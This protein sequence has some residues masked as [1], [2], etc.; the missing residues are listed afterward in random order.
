MKNRAAIYIR[1]SKEE[2]QQK[3][4]SLQMQRE[5]LERYAEEKGF[6]LAGIYCDDGQSGVDFE[7]PAFQAL[8]RDIEAGKID[9]LLTKDLSR[10]GRNSAR[11]TD[12]LD[13]YFPSKGVRYI[14]V[15]E[16]V[17]TQAESSANLIAPIANAV[18]ELYAR[19]ISQKIRSS[20]YAR[21][22]AGQYIGSFAPYG[23]RKSNKEHGK[24]ERDWQAAAVV[25]KIFTWA[26]AGKTPAQIAEKMEREQYCTP[27]EYRRSGMILRS[28]MRQYRWEAGTVRKLLRNPCYMGMLVQGRTQKISFKAKR[29]KPLPKECWRVCMQAQEAIVSQEMYTQV[30]RM[31]AGR[32]RRPRGG[33]QNLFAGIAWCA[34]CGARMSSAQ[35]GGHHS[36]ICGA[37]KRRGKDACS[38]HRLSYEALLEEVEDKIMMQL[39]TASVQKETMM[40]NLWQQ[41]QAIAKT[42][43][44]ERKRQQIYNK[45][46]HLYDDKYSGNI[47][48]ELFLQL[49]TQYEGELSGIN[50]A[51]ALQ[52][53]MEEQWQRWKKMAERAW[54]PSA[55]TRE[56]LLIMIERIEVAQPKA[57]LPMEITIQWKKRSRQESLLPNGLNV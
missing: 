27:L 39:Q 40:E 5:I 8:M 24:L 3:Q 44:Q 15:N 17:D 9:I 54:N 14:S 41:L 34:D 28:Q 57:D 52:I 47:T 49:Q 35:S 30:Q 29:S 13:E 23:Y 36:L 22:E 32:R 55:L 56:M 51:L 38:S 53:E 6:S 18:N 10:L 11:T 16:G 7:R 50:G 42:G 12:L 25:R 1:L 46:R 20:L 21:M 4:G 45:L 26:S 43:Q 2:R 19:D 37:Y 31:L 33:W 48:E